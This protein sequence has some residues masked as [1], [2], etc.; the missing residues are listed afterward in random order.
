MCR[1]RSRRQLATA[2][3]LLDLQQQ[4]QQAQQPDQQQNQATHQQ[5]HQQRQDEEE[6]AESAVQRAERQLEDR[7]NELQLMELLVE[8]DRRIGQVYDALPMN[9]LLVVAT[10][11]GDMADLRRQQ[12]MKYRREQRLDGLPP[13]SSRDEEEF[14][15]MV[16]EQMKALCFCAVRL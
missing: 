5:Q 12:E 10:G 13:W 2:K 8:L 7:F 6:P 4:E 16:D 15:S 11:Q 3:Q 14:C 1:C 9:A